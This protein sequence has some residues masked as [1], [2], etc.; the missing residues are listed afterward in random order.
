VV[1]W[2]RRC[3]AIDA[4]ARMSAPPPRLMLDIV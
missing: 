4:I 3:V 2:T 1:G